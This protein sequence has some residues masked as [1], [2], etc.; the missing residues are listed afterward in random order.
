[1]AEFI[2][3]SIPNFA[4]IMAPLYELE[5][6]YRKYC[7]EAGH[8]L[9]LHSIKDAVLNSINT[10]FNDSVVQKILFTDASDVGIEGALFQM[11]PVGK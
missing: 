2:C 5:E 3:F 10:I 7:W 6:H 8:G 4:E 9:A 11:D 1:V